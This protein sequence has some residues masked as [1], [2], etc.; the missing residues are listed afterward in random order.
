M[1]ISVIF[2]YVMNLN[3]GNGG[4]AS[5]TL[6]L[7][8]VV[9][10]RG[11]EVECY[12]VGSSGP[13]E[14]K[15]GIAFH[16]VESLVSPIHLICDL[17][18]LVLFD[19]RRKVMSQFRLSGKMK[20]AIIYH[21]A[22]FD[23]G[24]KGLMHFF[25]RW[26]DTF[27]VVSAF[28]QK[29]AKNLGISSVEVLR[30]QVAP[31]FRHRAPIIRENVSLNFLFVGALVKEKGLP[32]LFDA[33]CLFADTHPQARLRIVGSSLLWSRNSPDFPLI[34]HPQIHFVGELGPEQIVDE[35]V[36]SSFVVLPSE[37]E[38]CGL[39]VL[40]GMWFGCVP[41][42][43][44]RGGLPEIVTDGVTGFVM[45]ELSVD[46]LVSKLKEAA[47]L[48]EEGFLELQ[49]SCIASVSRTDWKDSA[50]VLERVVRRKRVF[51]WL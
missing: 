26:A 48:T 51:P 9:A 42:V 25:R 6:S 4:G 45:A 3:G 37:M 36:R 35:Y 38:S 17:V 20:R 1:K 12:L 15:W 14:R 5:S 10:D 32:V 29:L 16:R 40:D 28:P 19:D 22:V 31:V 8:Q 34:Q 30:N 41:I 33:F 24:N 23:S 11:H 27:F 13:S 21:N 46:G 43:S 49:R 47:S 18:V 2:P 39:S 50:Q 7:M 44:N